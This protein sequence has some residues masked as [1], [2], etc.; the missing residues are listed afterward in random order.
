MHDAENA[1]DKVCREQDEAFC[2]TYSY[3]ARQQEE[4]QRIRRKYLP[5]TADKMAQLRRLDQ[6]ATKPGRIAAMTLGVLGTLI[7]GIG[8]CCTMVWTDYFTWGIIIGI[9]GMAT[10]AAAFPLYKAVT[11]RQREKLAPVIMKLSDELLQ[12][13]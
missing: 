8:M 7:M 4:I 2:Y 5:Q 1:T 9:L 11:A 13:K 10:M 12:E 3:S 6:S